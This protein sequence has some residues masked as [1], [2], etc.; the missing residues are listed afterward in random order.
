MAEA[1]AT[2]IASVFEAP[3][4]RRLNYCSPPRGAGCGSGS[5]EVAASRAEEHRVVTVDV[6]NANRALRDDRQ[7]AVAAVDR[8]PVGAAHRRDAVFPAGAEATAVVSRPQGADACAGLGC[9]GRREAGGEVP[10][11]GTAQTA[12]G[13]RPAEPKRCPR[14]ARRSW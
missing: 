9:R 13:A 6:T 14:A 12:A 8:L 2:A 3:V 1:A 10:A 7:R 5:R 11:T 4:R